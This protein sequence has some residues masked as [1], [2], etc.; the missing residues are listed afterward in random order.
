[1]NYGVP[2]LYKDLDIFIESVFDDELVK[3]YRMDVGL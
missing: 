2:L 1:M 3:E